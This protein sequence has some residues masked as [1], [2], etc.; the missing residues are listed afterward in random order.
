MKSKFKNQKN[1]FSVLIK[2]GEYAA[3]ILRKVKGALTYTW[4]PSGISYF[5]RLET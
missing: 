5:S 2:K 4:P 1:L 3:I